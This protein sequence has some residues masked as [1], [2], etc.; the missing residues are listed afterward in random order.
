MIIGSWVLWE[1]YLGKIIGKD[2]K[3]LLIEFSA[4]FKSRLLPEDVKQV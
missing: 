3:Y 4:G 2:G 1:Q